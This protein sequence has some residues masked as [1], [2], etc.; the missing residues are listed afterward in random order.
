[1]QQDEHHKSEAIERRDLES[2]RF[3]LDATIN[4][5]HIITTVMLIFALFKWGAGIEAMLMR[6]DVTIDTLKD[7]QM[8]IANDTQAQLLEVNRKLDRLIER[9]MIKHGQ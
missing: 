3:R 1:M 6:H 5:T 9:S 7:R 4:I 2:R 8:Q